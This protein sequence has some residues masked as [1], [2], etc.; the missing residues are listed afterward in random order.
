MGTRLKLHET[1]DN[2][3][4]KEQRRNETND[5]SLR[6]KK[7]QEQ[8]QKDS[9]E[10]QF[11]KVEK[12]RKSKD[13]EDKRLKEGK[14][15]RQSETEEKRNIKEDDEKLKPRQRKDAEMI[16]TQEE[17]RKRIEENRR[18]D[19]SNWKLIKYE[20][21]EKQTNAFHGGV[22]CQVAAMEGILKEEDLECLVSDEDTGS[23]LNVDEKLASSIISIYSKSGEKTFQVN[24]L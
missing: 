24:I 16:G 12:N 5:S 13:E 4:N 18:K 9:E 15:R 11:I 20:R 3:V 17:E 23:V 6:T 7:G 2:N 8:K 19:P 21:P 10:E 22:C 1:R 14:E